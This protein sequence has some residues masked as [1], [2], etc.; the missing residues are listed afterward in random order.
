MSTTLNQPSLYEQLSGSNSIEAV[1]AQFYARI[2]A[3]E[4]LRP[5]FANVD[6]DRLKGH[7]THFIIYALGGPNNYT[8]R[9]MRT[10]HRGLG[11]TEDQFAAVAGHLID[12]LVSF[13]VPAELTD[14]VIEQIAQLKGD[15]VER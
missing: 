8:G 12:T 4:T 5:M 14:Q 9:S 6:M 15:I 11:I 13:N 1:V 10:A 7:Q 2:F 3:D